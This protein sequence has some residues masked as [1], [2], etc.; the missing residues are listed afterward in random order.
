MALPKE[1]EEENPKALAAT[2]MPE[3]PHVPEPTPGRESPKVFGMAEGVAPILS[4]GGHW[5]HPLTNQGPKA[6]GGIGPAFPN[7]PNKTTSLPS[8]DPYSTSAL[9]IDASLGAR[10]AADPTM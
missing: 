9:S 5:G 6:E 3:A 10:V 1:E 4:N 2:T 7:D 8:E